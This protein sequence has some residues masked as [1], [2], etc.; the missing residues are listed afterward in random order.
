[1]VKLDCYEYDLED[2]NGEKYKGEFSV[3]EGTP[4]PIA[5][6]KKVDTIIINRD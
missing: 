3:K 1:M 5:N 2:V 6:A 4:S